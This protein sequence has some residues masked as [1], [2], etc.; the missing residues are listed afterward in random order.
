MIDY[1]DGKILWDNS[2]NWSR[3]T[4]DYNQDIL[5]VKYGE[6]CIIDV[7]DYSDGCGGRHFAIMIIDYTPYPDKNDDSRANA[8]HPP[9]ACIRCKDKSDMLLQLQRA[10]DTYPALIACGI[11]GDGK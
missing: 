9:Y 7:G 4:Y 11:K 5:Q 1:K 10:I 2:D 8:W 3:D 6:N